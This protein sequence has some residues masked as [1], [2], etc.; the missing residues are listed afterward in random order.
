MSN[1]ICA[2]FVKLTVLSLLVVT[3]G[4]AGCS[5]G[6]GG[7]T[8]ITG[9]TTS[10]AGT[11][12]TN[13][14]R[15]STSEGTIGTTGGAGTGGGAG[16]SGSSGGVGG[17]GGT[18][19]AG[20][21]GGGPVADAAADQSATTRPPDAAP[22]GG[23][24]GSIGTGVGGRDAGR[25][26]G[27]SGKAGAG[28]TAGAGDGSGGSAVDA[29]A[30]R[31][32]DVPAVSDGVTSP[33]SNATDVNWK[34]NA[35]RPTVLLIIT[36]DALLDSTPA[37]QTFIRHKADLGVPAY[38]VSV[39][40]MI[41]TET[42]VDD[43]EKVKRGI[44]YAARN[45]GTR[46]VLLA[47]GASQVP[48]R[49]RRVLSPDDL[50]WAGTNNPSDLY[51]SD[52]Y[53]GPP[54]DQSVAT[55]ETWDANNDG[56]YDEE[57]WVAGTGLSYNPDEVVGYPDIALGRVPATTAAELAQFLDKVI[58]FETLSQKPG[59]GRATYFIDKQYPG[60]DS[61][62]AQ[63]ESSAPS[64]LNNHF[65][66]G[67]AS[68]DILPAGY[69]P[70]SAE[71]VLVAAQDSDWIFYVGHGSNDYWGAGANFTMN[72]AAQFYNTGN[73]PVVGAAACDT[74]AFS[75][76]VYVA[77]DA[78]WNTDAVRAPYGGQ[79]C[80]A[81]S[82]TCTDY[83][84]I[85]Y[86]GETIVTPDNFGTSLLAS[87]MDLQKSQACL[88]DIWLQA[89]QQYWT[90]NQN[91]TDVL[92]TPRIYLGVMM[93]FGDPSLRLPTHSCI[94]GSSGCGD[95]GGVSGNGGAGGTG[96]AAGAVADAGAD[97]NGDV[98]AV[99]DGVPPA[100]DADA[101]SNPDSKMPEG[102]FVPTGSMTV[103]RSGHTATLLASGKVLIAG[104][105]GD[106]PNAKL[107]AELYDPAAGTFT[108]TGVMTVARWDHTATLLQN[109]KVLIAGGVGGGELSVSAE[110]Y[111]PAAGTF[112]ATGSLTM[113]RYF[114]T[115]TLL[116]SGKV[117]VAGGGD[118][119]GKPLASAE[120]Y[121]PVIRT[122]TA[123][124]NMTVAREF[125]AATLLENGKVL[126]TGGNNLPSAE[127]YDPSAGT[128]A[129]TGSMTATRSGSTATLMTNG[130]VL[131][132]GPDSSAELYDPAAGTFTP[133]GSMIMGRSYDTATLLTSGKVLIAGGGDAKPL[134]SAELYDPVIGTFTAISNMTVAR[135]GHSATLL[136]NGKVLVAGGNTPVI[137]PPSLG[138][139]GCVEDLA[140]AELYQ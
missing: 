2:A 78:S 68:T 113:G 1:R 134:A 119:S 138:A 99:S 110:L 125:H 80:M 140:S 103:A 85:A 83:G 69:S 28:G 129:P 58:A 50:T 133:T 76:C 102:V 61:L 10:F 30:E 51:Y 126:I 19:P 86:F 11:T 96:G 16:T 136:P 65:G 116:T 66:L 41:A 92:G 9:G 130:I 53:A 23:V 15:I 17:S 63:I 55:F 111:D 107:Y 132:A 34:T 100:S 101:D 117:L 82:W 114:P 43:P 91:S 39:E 74:G 109:G 46:Y 95:A 124:S 22:I 128:F 35:P 36:S 49:R 12:G 87:V 3:V 25:E 89:Q 97:R 20:G 88:G 77:K 8:R 29:G 121:D 32:A 137:C 105:D 27:S 14:G 135:E 38:A 139:V 52:I 118:A 18:A 13:G 122:F 45:L 60:A 127:L 79:N 5:S 106:G 120:L 56:F 24:D 44:Y 33:E 62:A 37:I 7:T 104:G 48:V 67:Y 84:G 72:D 123:I 115:A 108:A 98:P 131:I 26:G 6:S 90:A 31:S 21:R 71:D 81:S 70:G 59:D 47:G 73:F 57:N 112:A 75:A 42:G 54:S 4:A 93:L 40:S 94:V 64:S